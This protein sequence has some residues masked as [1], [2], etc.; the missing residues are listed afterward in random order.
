MTISHSNELTGYERNIVCAV[1]AG[2]SNAEIAR[3]LGTTAGTIRV[4][5]T[6][7]YE[8]TFT[9]SRVALAMLAVRNGWYK[10]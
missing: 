1:A 5:M 6:A 3:M 7:I 10:P 4:R 8:K 9:T 2:R